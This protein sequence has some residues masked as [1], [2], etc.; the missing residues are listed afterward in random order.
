VAEEGKDVAI[1]LRL[2]D[3]AP[4]VLT[5]RSI[6][7]KETWYRTGTTSGAWRMGLLQCIYWHLVTTLSISYI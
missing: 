1:S 6:G 3:M 5:L 2:H 7:L 4:V